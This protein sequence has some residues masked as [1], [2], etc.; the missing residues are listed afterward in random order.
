LNSQVVV[1]LICRLCLDQK[2]IVDEN[3]M[4]QF[5]GLPVQEKDPTKAIE[6]KG[7]NK[8]LIYTKYGTHRWSHGVVIVDIN[9]KRVYFVMQFISYKLLHKFHKD[10]CPIRVVVVAK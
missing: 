6:A 4:F 7:M 8:D 9:E 1:Q 5:L 3:T 2:Y 10:K